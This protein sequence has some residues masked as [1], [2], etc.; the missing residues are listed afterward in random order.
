MTPEE[1]TANPGMPVRHVTGVM[2]FLTGAIVD[3]SHLNVELITTEGNLCIG[4][5]ENLT[6]YKRQHASQ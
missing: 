4:W 3:Y 2:G 5:P 1:C 6:P